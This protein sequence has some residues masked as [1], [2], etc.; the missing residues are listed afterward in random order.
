MTQDAKTT[1]QREEEILTE[2][3]RA[4]GS[5]RVNFLAERLGV[6]KE[7]IRRNL[8]SL[9]DN[10]IVRKVHGG[11]HLVHRL[12]EAPFQNRMDEKS[13]VKERLAARVA[14]LISDGDSV[15]LDVGSS[16]AY[17]AM[18]LRA[19]KKLYVV[20][21]SIFVAQTLSMRNG[22]RVFLAGGELRPHDGG[23]FGA[24][25]LELVGRFNTQFAVFSIGAVNAESGFMLHDFQEAN[26]ARIAARNAQVCIVVTVAE[27]FAKR[28]PVMLDHADR[29]DIL[30][31]DAPPPDDIGRMLKGHGIEFLPAE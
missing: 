30:V 25:A 29:F 3:R 7:T 15:F 5:C 26:I 19:H 20:T 16:T 14:G 4:G 28:A 24:E 21:N 11:V 9:E 18:A 2:L 12:H 17:V 31:S 1:N 23:A 13:S 6:S 8:R 10:A 27:K 22:N